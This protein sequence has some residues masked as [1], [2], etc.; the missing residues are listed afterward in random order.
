MKKTFIIAMLAIRALVFMTGCTNE[1]EKKES[2]PFVKGIEVEEIEVEDILIEEILT[3]EQLVENAPA[4]MYRTQWYLAVCLK[5]KET[6]GIYDRDV[7]LD[8]EPEEVRNDGE[9]VWITYKSGQKEVFQ[10]SGY[11]ILGCQ[12]WNQMVRAD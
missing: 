6:G 1:T 2:E 11:S 3:E 9:Q 4:G 12:T 5:D 7:I 10:F 8:E